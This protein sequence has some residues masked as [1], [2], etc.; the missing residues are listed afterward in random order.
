MVHDGRNSKLSHVFEVN[1]NPDGIIL[2]YHCYLEPEKA[3][4][5]ITKLNQPLPKYVRHSFLEYP[6]L[7]NLKTLR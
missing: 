6:D 5:G 4:L 2:G 3:A 1:E 7:C